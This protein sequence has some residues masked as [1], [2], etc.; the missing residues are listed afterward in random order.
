MDIYKTNNKYIMIA[1]FMIFLYLSPLYIL[2]QNAHVLILDNVDGAVASL[3]VLAHSGKI[4]GSMHS[5]IPQVM[6]GIPRNTFGTEF[7]VQVLLYRFLAPFT[8]YVINLTLVHL[9]AFLGMYLL[10]RKYVLPKKKDELITVGVALAFAL[11]PFWPYGGLSVAGQPLV[12]YAFLNIRARIDHKVDWLILTLVPFYSSFIFSFVFFLFIMGLW[13]LYD[14]IVNRKINI[15]F[16]AAIFFMGLMYSIVEYRLIYNTF[17]D[18]GFVSIRSEF[19]LSR[20]AGKRAALKE[21]IT[22]F[23]F[24]QYHAASLQQAAIIPAALLA[25]FISMKK[26]KLPYPLL[27]LLFVAGLISIWYGL[28]FFKAWVPIKQHIGFL[29]E[30]NL[31]RFH[32]LHPLLWYLI[33]A[34]ALKIIRTGRIGKLLV[35][36]LLAVQIGFLFYNNDEIVQGKAGTPTYKEFYA[37]SMFKDIARFIGQDQKNYRVVS[38]GIHPSIAQYNGF[39]TLDGYSSNYPLEYKHE[40]RK[41]MQPE[42]DKSP[43]YRDYFDSLGGSRCYIFVQKLCYNSMMYK[44][45]NIKIEKLDLNT[46]Q[47]KKMGG[48][49]IFSACEILNSKDLNLKLLKVFE[50]KDS[51]WKIYL[52]KV[53]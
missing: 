16:L 9:I 44:D 1:L 43:L 45:N 5:T 29:R 35:V 14:L 41:I 26:K 2:G 10:L 49:Y 51:A 21:C 17:F 33:F 6:N 30:F 20:I 50:N 23:I 53:Q 19:P 37:E 22:N 46:A 24:G 48:K 12:L 3:K 27:G 15:R 36:V 13:W 18:P 47:L 25:I 31:S 11:L 8:A 40:F 52:Y 39:Y 32:W 4:F 34:L 42:L 38:I 28:W 7:N